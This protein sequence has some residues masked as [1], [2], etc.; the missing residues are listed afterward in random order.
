MIGLVQHKGLD[1]VKPDVALVN[2]IKHASRGGDKH[3]N[4][5][6]ELLDLGI[7]FH[8]PKQSKGLHPGVPGNVIEHP[9]DLH[10]KLPGGNQDNALDTKGTLAGFDLVD[11]INDGDA[12][13]AVLPVPVW[14]M[15]STSS[16]LWMAGMDLY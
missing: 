9:A 1:I 16:P 11:L 2:Q 8:P 3:I 7:L 14:A 10:G 4:A 5:V 6:L 13:A 15:A 12:K